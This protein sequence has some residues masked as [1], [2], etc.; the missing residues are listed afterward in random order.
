MPNVIDSEYLIGLMGQNIA[1]KKLNMGNL[2]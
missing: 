2:S 1:K